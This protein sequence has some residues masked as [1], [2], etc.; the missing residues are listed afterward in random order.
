MIIDIVETLSILDFCPWL[1][2]CCMSRTPRWHGTRQTQTSR[3]ASRKQC[4]CGY[5]WHF[6]CCCLLTS[7]TAWAISRTDPSS[8]TGSTL[9]KWFLTIS[10]LLFGF[11]SSSVSFIKNRQKLG[12]V[13]MYVCCCVLV[14]FCVYHY[15]CVC[16]CACVCIHVCV[17]VRAC[18][19]ARVCVC[20]CFCVISQV[21]LIVKTNS[22]SLQFDMR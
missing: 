19:H 14:T 13:Y 20:V 9:P 16:T 22:A 21:G 5:Q 4:W 10:C 6:F 15:I 3:H 8:G 18:A 7:C 2:G 12:S 11:Y 1:S 17:C